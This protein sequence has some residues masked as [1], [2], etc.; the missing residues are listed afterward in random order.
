[1][2]NAGMS[3]LIIDKGSG[4]AAPP[5]SGGGIWIPNN[6]TLRAAGHNDSRESIRA[7]STITEDRVAP[8]R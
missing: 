8:E 5:Q 3:V 2:R 6:P 7:T 1:M 4:S